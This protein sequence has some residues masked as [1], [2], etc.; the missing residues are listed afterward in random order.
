MTADA[1]TPSDDVEK[2]VVEVSQGV[3]V[4]GYRHVPMGPVGAGYIGNQPITHPQAD[5]ALADALRQIL[6][7][8]DPASSAY[9]IAAA[10]LGEG[11]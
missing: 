6:G 10:A 7:V 9:K 3:E 2:Y 1:Q 4:A 8:T 11:K 5:P